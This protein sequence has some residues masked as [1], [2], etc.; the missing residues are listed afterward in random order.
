MIKDLRR[1]YDIAR[2]LRTAGDPSDGLVVAD[3]AAPI[4]VAVPGRPDH[5]LV[6]TGML[7]LLD[8]D[9]RRV[10]FAH[11]RAHLTYHHDLLVALTAAS[12]ALNPLLRPVRDAVTFLVERWADE[13]AAAETGDRD[14]AAQAVARA[15][16][17]ATGPGTAL[18]FGGR[19]VIGRIR[20]LSTPRPRPHRRRLL[21]PS[22]TGI[23]A[24]AATIEF[25]ALARAWIVHV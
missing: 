10:L 18:G 11:E 16:P 4:A 14:L 6:T 5:L 12:A 15:A 22:L 2:R 7:R 24:T 20:A 8:A 19:D 9:E 3:W 25:V 13:H 1:R 23:A 17:A 21:A